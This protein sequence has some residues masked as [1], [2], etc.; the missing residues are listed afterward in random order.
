MAVAAMAGYAF[1]RI[2]FPGQNVLFVVVLLGL[3]IPSEGT[4]VPLFRMFHVLG[5]TDTQWPLI[6]VS[7]LDAPS[8]LATLI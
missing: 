4:I 3:L 8:V 5:L 1:A 6:L 2:R 7:I